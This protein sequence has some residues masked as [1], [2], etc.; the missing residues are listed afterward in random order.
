MVAGRL[1]HNLLFQND[2]IEVKNIGKGEYNTA[3]SAIALVS[4]DVDRPTPCNPE[5]R[6]PALLPQLRL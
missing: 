5:R 6:R 2:F 3:Q 4:L 1:C